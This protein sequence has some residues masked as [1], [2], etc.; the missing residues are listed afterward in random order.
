MNDDK[1]ATNK[2][3]SL[4]GLDVRA[5]EMRRQNHRQIRDQS[6]QCNSFGN[7]RIR[8]EDTPSHPG[9]INYQVQQQ[10]R[11]RQRQQHHHVQQVRH[12]KQLDSSTSVAAPLIKRH[13]SSSNTT[14]T[15]TTTSISTTTVENTP[16]STPLLNPYQNYNKQPPPP[17]Q[18][19]KQQSQDWE[20]DITIASTALKLQPQQD[21]EDFDREFY[22]ADDENPTLLD[23]HSSADYDILSHPNSSSSKI[24][25]QTP[26]NTNTATATATATATTATSRESAR[27]RDLHADQTKW[28]ENRLL[29]SGVATTTQQRYN[30]NLDEEETRVQLLVHQV[31]P[32]FLLLDAPSSSASNQNTHKKLTSSSGTITAISSI[33]TVSHVKDPTSDMAK[34]AR[35]GSVSLRQL[36]EHKEKHAMRQKF[37]ELGGHNRM[38]KVILQQQQQQKQQQDTGPNNHN[39]TK[40]EEGE[41]DEDNIAINYKKTFGYATH[42]KTKIS[43]TNT[44]ITTTQSDFTKR[45]TIRQQREYLPVY[46][47][48]NELL[49]V[50][51]ENSITIVVGETGK[52]K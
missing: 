29:S 39:M 43:D 50:I 40:K 41:Q 17:K 22:L 38:G 19:N 46:S 47:V 3:K 25:R 52:R 48:R 18:F 42:L 45:K 30:A 27:K 34:C 32:P 21:D 24:S 37:W 36:R 35:E 31:K 13:A 14:T 26:S 8:E 23:F 15:A 11:Q 1:S 10:I 49:N 6:N 7:R 4:L 12:R 16:N 9:G 2:K 51:R 28:E 20:D 44:T 5:A 33:T